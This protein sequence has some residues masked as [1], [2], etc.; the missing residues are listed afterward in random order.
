MS[1]EKY[2]SPAI[3]YAYPL[4][5]IYHGG[6]RRVSALDLNYTNLNERSCIISNVIADISGSLVFKHIAISILVSSQKN[7]GMDG[8]IV[9]AR[10]AYSYLRSK[11][12]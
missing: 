10:G 2:T 11:E 12:E 4:S 6:K 8:E 9:T 5:S 7:D 3:V 1:T